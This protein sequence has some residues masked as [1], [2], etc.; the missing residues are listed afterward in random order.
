MGSRA[1]RDVPT[2]PGREDR[3]AAP[4][5][6]GEGL[7]GRTSPAHIPSSDFVDSEPCVGPQPGVSAAA[8]GHSGSLHLCKA[9]LNWPHSWPALLLYL[10]VATWPHL[11]GSNQLNLFSVR[12]FFE[13]LSVHPSCT[14]F[15]A[16]PLQDRMD[17][18]SEQGRC[19]APNILGGRPA[20]NRTLQSVHLGGPLGQVVWEPLAAGLLSCR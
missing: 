13:R 17:P 8:A 6:A 11:P 19:C 18:S 20:L 5:G 7:G 15:T 10:P 12:L 14:G 9:S 2:C 16:N 4:P 1:W 3:R